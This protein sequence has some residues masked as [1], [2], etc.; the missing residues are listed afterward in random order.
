MQLNASFGDELAA[1]PKEVSPY[2]KSKQNNEPSFR[3]PHSAC[4]RQL[5]PLITTQRPTDT[6]ITKA[7]VCIYII[8]RSGCSIQINAE[9]RL[10]PV[11]YHRPNFIIRALESPSIRLKGSPPPAAPMTAYATRPPLHLI[12]NPRIMNEASRGQSR[13]TSARLA[14]KEDVPYVNGIGHDPEPTK[15]R[16]IIEGK[17]AKGRLNGAS[18]KPTAKRKPGEIFP[19]LKC[20]CD[21]RQSLAKGPFGVVW[22]VCGIH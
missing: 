3:S 9:K 13:R 16:Q 17:Q 20:G 19:A 5:R 7:S 8:G 15:G 12:D 2:T 1:K 11:W 18:T 22:R 14:E 4:L 6:I 10:I 21:L